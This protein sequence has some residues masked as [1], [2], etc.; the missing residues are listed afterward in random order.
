MKA[1]M[2][3]SAMAG[4]LVATL[5]AIAWGSGSREPVDE[6]AHASR[7]TGTFFESRLVEVDGVELHIVLAGPF[8]G[9]PVVLLH[10]FPEYWYAWRTHMAMLARAGFRVVAPDQRGAN[11]SDKPSAAAE[12]TRQ[13]LADDVIGILDSLGWEKAFIAGHDVGAGTTWQVVLES[14]QRVQAAIVFNGT[15][16]LALNE[17]RP[18]DDPDS[19]SWFRDFFLLPFVPELVSRTYD[20]WLVSYYLRST[21]R[22]G[23]FGEEELALYKSAWDRGGAMGTM[24]NTFR[25]PI[26][27]LR[28]MPPGGRPE[29]PFRV[30]WGERDAFIPRE[31][32]ALNQRYLPEG[33]IV[34]LPEAGHWLLH[35][36]PERTAREMIDF[37]G[38]SAFPPSRPRLPGKKRELRGETSPSSRTGRTQ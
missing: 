5:L 7:E 6:V 34:V 9:P 30:V 3:S 13:R 18:Q 28:R 2:R 29:V 1:R 12:Y 19:V 27:P 25:A 20:W 11:R 10:G 4:V 14:P 17:S 16:L 33:A 36:E 35:E 24:I 15:H 8:D 21:S 22:S 31:R 32:I 26:V 23:T 38:E 37:F